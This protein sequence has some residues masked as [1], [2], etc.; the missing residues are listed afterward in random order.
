MLFRNYLLM[1]IWK[2]I[3]VIRKKNEFIMKYLLVRFSCNR[4]EH[5]LTWNHLN[6]FAWSIWSFT[7]F[8]RFV[9]RCLACAAK[10]F[11]TWTG[12][13]LLLTANCWSKGNAN[14]NGSSQNY[15]HFHF[16]KIGQKFGQLVF[17]TTV[18]RCTEIREWSQILY[19]KL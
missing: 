13:K 18:V 10:Y 17:R 14:A 8:T 1:I 16:D 5:F 12:F 6:F 9:E 7:W 4:Y 15:E 11:P 3:F 19:T 2:D